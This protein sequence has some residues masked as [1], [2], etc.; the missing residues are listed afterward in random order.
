MLAN[1]ETRWTRESLPK[2]Q[3]PEGRHK[4][5]P[6]EI[7]TRRVDG[8][9]NYCR[10]NS[11]GPFTQLP[12]AAIVLPPPEMDSVADSNKG[13]GKEAKSPASPN[14]PNSADTLA[15]T[16][17]EW[18]V[19]ESLKAE[20]KH[21]KAQHEDWLLELHADPNRHALNQCKYWRQTRERLNAEMALINERRSIRKRFR[22][23]ANHPEGV[24][25]W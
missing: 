15:F 7:T 21:A 17:R 8:F 20:H 9:V 14:T 2:L 16:D 11:K 10:N 12:S 18:E 25:N 6:E 22:Q 4:T 5:K 24:E 3:I 1:Q 19:M 13:E 23:S